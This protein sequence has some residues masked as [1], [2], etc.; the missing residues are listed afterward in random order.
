MVEYKK[1]GFFDVPQKNMLKKKKK[2]VFFNTPGLYN[3]I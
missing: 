2:L 1:P 3:I